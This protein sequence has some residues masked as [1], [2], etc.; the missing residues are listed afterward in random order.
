[1]PKAAPVPYTPYD[2]TKALPSVYKKKAAKELGEISDQVS[3]HLESFRRWLTSMPHLKCTTDDTFLLAFLRQAKYNHM[4][5]QR[6]LD[7]F[8]TFRTSPTEGNPSWFEDTATNRENWNKWI[9]MKCWA[10]LGFTQEGSLVILV[11]STNINLNELSIA[12]LQGPSHIWNDICLADPRAQIGGICMIMDFTNF[13]KEDV[14]RMFEPKM[15]KVATKYFQECLPFRIK[16]LI[17]YNTPK[18][19]EAMFNLYSE[20][21]NEKIKSRILVLGSDFSPAFDAVPG[22]KDLMSDSYGG[23]NKLS[24]EDLCEKQESML[25]SLPDARPAFAIAVDES[26]RPKECRNQFGVY[27]DFS[28]DIMGKS[29]IY[30]KFNQD[31]I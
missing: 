19:F 21:L 24:F 20:W 7:K 12:D 2:A 8:C 31:E 18:V 1:M 22:L 13:R 15:S 6:R 17:Y 4:K 16:K 28:T 23:D 5:A 27:K 14:M 29:G 10:P 11:K 30:V 9:D 25:K 26:K 3:A